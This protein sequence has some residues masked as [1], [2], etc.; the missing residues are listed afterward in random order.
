M[1]VVSGGELHL[2]VGLSRRNDRD[3]REVP[4][5]CPIEATQLFKETTPSIQVSTLVSNS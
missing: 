1:K 5:P 2:V 4:H 3:I